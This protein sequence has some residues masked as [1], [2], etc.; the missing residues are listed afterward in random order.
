MFAIVDCNNFYVSC[1]R[2][3]NPFLDNKPV[4]VLSNNDGCII[5]RSQEAKDLGVKMGDPAFKIEEL[6]QRNNI[7]VYSSNYTLYGDMSR[8]VMSI[9]STFVPCVEIYSIDECFLDFSGFESYHNV[10]D[11]ALNIRATVLKCTGIPVCIGIAPTKTLA[12]VAN[13]IAKKKK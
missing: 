7:Q 12:K 5:S 11:I 10:R 3:F 4:V 9:L 6:I 2:V 1:E 8:R 13:K